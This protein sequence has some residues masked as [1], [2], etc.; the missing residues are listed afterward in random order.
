MK[1]DIE[2]ANKGQSEFDADDLNLIKLAQEYSDED[3]ARELLERLRWPDGAICPHCKNDGKTKP[4]SKLTPKAGS[5][6]AVVGWGGKNRTGRRRRSP[7]TSRT[8]M[9][10]A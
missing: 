7:R 6:S 10:R 4:N 1:N 5:K 3:K 2:S 8:R 9:S